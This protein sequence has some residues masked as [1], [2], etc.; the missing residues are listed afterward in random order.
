MASTFPEARPVAP[1]HVREEVSLRALEYLRAMRKEDIAYYFNADVALRVHSF[2]EATPVPVNARTYRV[3]AT[4]GTPTRLYCPNSL[5][6]L[7][8]A[9]RSLLVGDIAIDLDMQ[10][11]MF[12]ALK[13]TCTCFHVECPF[14]TEYCERRDEK[15]QSLCASDGI[16]RKE[17]K[18][19]FI[20]AATSSSQARTCD[21]FLGLFDAE[22][23]RLQ[24]ELMLKAELAWAISYARDDGNRAGS[25]VSIVTQFLEGI[26]L[27]AA[28]QVVSDAGL[29]VIA[30]MFD[31]LLVSRTKNANARRGGNVDAC[32]SE[33]VADVDDVLDT[34]RLCVALRSR[35]NAILPG[36]EQAWVVKP[37][38]YTIRRK[39][40][41]GESEKALGDFRVPRAW[42]PPMKKGDARA[43]AFLCMAREFDQSH[44]RVD[45]CFVDTEW[46]ATRPEVL[47]LE[48]FRRRYMDK[49]YRW[50]DERTNEEKSDNFIN[51]WLYKYDKKRVF[52]RFECIPH[53]LTVP[54]NVYNTWIP[55]PCAKRPPVS[56]DAT[57]ATQHAA[58]EVLQ[59]ILWHLFV[60]CGKDVSVFDFNVRFYA[61]AV[62][63]PHLRG[64][65]MVIYSGAEG[66]GK[67]TWTKLLRTMFG[68]AFLSTTRPEEDVWG[69][70]NAQ[71]ERKFFIEL[72]ET[73]RSNMHEFWGRVNGMLTENRMSV[74]RMRTDTYEASNFIRFVGTTNNSIPVN[75]GRRYAV[76]ESAN[77]FKFKHSGGCACDTC[78]K[79][80][81]YHSEMNTHIMQSEENAH[82]FYSFLMSIPLPKNCV[83]TER[84]IPATE[85]QKRIKDASSTQQ[86]RFLHH[87]VR[88]MSLCSYEAS[89]HDQFGDPVSGGRLPFRKTNAT[90]AFTSADLW[91]EFKL[92]RDDREPNV[93]HIK[94]EDDLRR[95][96]GILCASIEDVAP[97]CVRKS[98]AYDSLHKMRNR[99]WIFDFDKLK[100]HLFED[101]EEED[102][103]NG[104][105]VNGGDG[106]STHENA[107][108]ASEGDAQKKAGPSADPML[109]ISSMIQT[110]V[111]EKWGKSG[112]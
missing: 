25:F 87:F 46:N 75:H 68:D 37:P 43:D 103:M 10:N 29:H 12:T 70:F 82:L 57:E 84:D 93:T 16:S 64:G 9:V 65:V 107:D 91:S 52:Q 19:I 31:G 72:A 104:D 62:Q 7:P 18:T 98:A 80:A 40:A 105:G 78:K 90:H 102:G 73:D 50:V 96:L 22:M 66:T 4:K 48:Q 44:C 51:E 17:A 35:C 11:Q 33:N 47:E 71:T 21:T 20:R 14:L 112:E 101:G 32:C 58:A 6:G 81:S 63:Y 24:S 106:Q 27:D 26:C 38:D 55:W 69:K 39:T 15:L 34:D 30:L 74:R 5:Q 110:F 13:Y 41:N 88:K 67:S 28:M 61:Q 109:H 94:S 108:A 95:K 23:K 79:L 86:Q 76:C 60:L 2:L 77:D 59:L 99:Q 83:I 56:T 89:L 1:R 42:S 97:G 54:P 36:I 53:T 3:S 92:W 45:T 111:S 8:T 85:I 49:M 100:R